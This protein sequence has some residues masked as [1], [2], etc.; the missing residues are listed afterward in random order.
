[1]DIQPLPRKSGG[2][3]KTDEY[4]R[5][6]DHLNRRVDGLETTEGDFTPRMLVV[7]K[8]TAEGT[9]SGLYTNSKLYHLSV[10]DVYESPRPS[11]LTVDDI[12]AELLSED[13]SV[14]DMSEVNNAQVAILGG[15]SAGGEPIYIIPAGGASLPT[16]QYQYQVYSMVAD[17]QGGWDYVR[18]HPINP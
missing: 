16:G 14:I 9:T 1:M 2:L 10:R 6:V 12:G 17:N 13:A 7:Q 4:N 11:S 8:G 18:A 5:L 3:V 15:Y